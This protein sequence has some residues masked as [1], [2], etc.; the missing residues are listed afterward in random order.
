MAMIRE[1]SPG[2]CEIAQTIKAQ[3]GARTMALDP[4]T[5]RLNQAAATSAP[6]AGKGPVFAMRP[7]RSW[8]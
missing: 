5:H 7:V 3:V 2:N 1:V 4:R 8:S 6:A